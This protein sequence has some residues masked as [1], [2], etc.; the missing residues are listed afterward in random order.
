MN[1]IIDYEKLKKE[2]NK[3][4]ENLYQ[5]KKNIENFDKETKNI[6]IDVEQ[7]KEF[8]NEEEH[9]KEECTILNDVEKLKNQYAQIK[10]EFE[11]YKKQ[12]ESLTTKTIN[13]QKAVNSGKEYLDIIDNRKKTFASA[14]ACYFYMKKQKSYKNYQKKV[15]N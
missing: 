9:S 11:N 1:K 3:Q 7:L 5:L 13:I 14:V 2:N 6:L 8:S 10:N 12:I 15:K 4:A